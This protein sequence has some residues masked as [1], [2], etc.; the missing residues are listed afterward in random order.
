MERRFFQ[1]LYF[2]PLGA[3]ERLFASIFVCTGRSSMTAMLLMLD[4]SK[5]SK[6]ACTLAGVVLLVLVSSCS[7]IR[8]VPT[9]YQ[10]TAEIVKSIDLVADD[11]GRLQAATSESERNRL[12]NKAIAV[13]DLQFYQ[14]VRE[15][16]A[17]RADSSA[18]VAGTTLGSS[19]VG[20]FVDSAS[21]KTNYALFSAGVIGAFGIVDK[22]Y[23]FDKTVPAL[24]AGMGA[25]RAESLVRIKSSQRG[26]IETYDGSAALADLED[27]FSAGTV[28]GAISEITT[29]SESDKL[30]ALNEV[31]SLEV[32]TDAEITRRK[33]IRDAVFAIDDLALDKA[34]KA[35]AALGLPEQKTAKEARVNLFKALRPGTPERISLVEQALK[36]SGLLK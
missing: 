3:A 13:I 33:V 8:G 21:A 1:E 29:R 14:F 6:V 12:Q 22:N 16:M 36:K 19:L 31:R 9:R 4:T 25:A 7:T 27:Y 5:A 35:L 20:V 24:V 17:N 11:L 18:A 10:E 26:S 28:L 2:D 34:N 23:F 32:P 30:A 15:L